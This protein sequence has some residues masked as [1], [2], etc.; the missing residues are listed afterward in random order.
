MI[1]GACTAASMERNRFSRM[2]GYGS[3]ACRRSHTLMA[4]YVVSTQKNAMMKV[5]DPPK[6]ATSSAMRLP[7]VVISSITSLGL[8]V[9]RNPNEVIEEMT[10]VG[11][12]I[13]DEVARF[14]G[15]WT[16]I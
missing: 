3:P 6:R 11:N 7:T 4:V 12:R 13:A 8:R 15:S 1:T 14:G 5:H 9:E 2:N 16:F 10:T